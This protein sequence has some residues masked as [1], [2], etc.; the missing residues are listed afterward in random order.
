MRHCLY[1]KRLFAVWDAKGFIDKKFCCQSCEEMWKEEKEYDLRQARHP[2]YKPKD[3]GYTMLELIIAVSII[4]IL[5]AIMSVHMRD[6]LR[7]AYEARTKGNLAIMRGAIGVYTADHDR[8]PNTLQMLIGPYL[9]VIPLKYTPAYHPEGN[10]VA[11]GPLSAMRDARSDWF[12]CNDAN[13][14]HYGEV[15]VNCVHLTLG[16]I[17]WSAY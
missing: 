5:A 11:N 15:V 9:S 10:S 2:R 6:T 16:G 1:C 8:P 12:Y 14:T 3:K 4:A 17:A 7:R 13:D